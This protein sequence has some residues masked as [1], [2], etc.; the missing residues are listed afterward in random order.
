MGH[1][2][3][4]LNLFLLVARFF[5]LGGLVQRGAVRGAG[6]G[7]LHHFELLV[8]QFPDAGFLRLGFLE[9]GAVLDVG[10][11]LVEF[12]L[13]FLDA[14]AGGVGFHLKLPAALGQA[15]HL[16]VVV[17]KGV[18]GGLEGGA[19][20]FDLAG[21]FGFQQRGLAGDFPIKALQPY[22]PLK[23]GVHRFA[24]SIPVKDR[25]A[26]AYPIRKK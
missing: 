10:F 9:D 7:G 25:V 12:L 4:A 11:H 26:M 14:F 20:F 24:G 21:Q 19:Q 16:G 13:G 6:F 5:F 8:F 3:F 22:Q 2:L 1:G 17:F 18:G 15:G 23:I